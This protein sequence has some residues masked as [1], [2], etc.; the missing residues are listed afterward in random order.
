MNITAYGTEAKNMTSSPTKPLPL[1]LIHVHLLLRIYYSEGVFFIDA[2]YM[3]LVTYDHAVN[4]L[5][6]KR[7]HKQE[8]SVN[9]RIL[10]A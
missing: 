1:S 10:P 7:S 8:R 2:P 4:G 9:N 3:E 6:K 5:E